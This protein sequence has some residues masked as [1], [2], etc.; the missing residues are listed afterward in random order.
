MRVVLDTNVFF[1]ALISPHG[2]PNE[3]YRAWQTDRFELVTSQKQIDEIRRASRYPKF[4][5]VFRPALIGTLINNMR[6][7]LVLERLHIEE[8]ADDPDDAFLLAMA[9]T[10]EADYLVTGDRRAG[11]LE[12][13]HIGRTSITT[14]SI[15]CSKVL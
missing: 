14:P 3:I 15:F 11:L 6:R 10:G 4:K 12:R 13:G 5:S 9:L 2:A 8:E 7:T 1:S